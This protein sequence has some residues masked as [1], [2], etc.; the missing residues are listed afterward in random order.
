MGLK[1]CIRAMYIRYAAILQMQRNTLCFEVRKVKTTH[2]NK[3]YDCRAYVRISTP[4]LV[5]GPTSPRALTLASRFNSA[6]DEF[7]P[8]FA[9]RKHLL[10][11]ARLPS[12]GFGA[13]RGDGPDGHRG[14]V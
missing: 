3:F 9:R 5:L 11:R 12:R 2:F 8:E 4:P 6:R 1:M 7:S 13:V 10:P 14:E